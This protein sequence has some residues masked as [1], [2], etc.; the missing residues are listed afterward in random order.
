VQEE[1]PYLHV[2]CVS[3]RLWLDIKVKLYNRTTLPCVHIIIII[4]TIIIIIIIY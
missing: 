1:T 2:I 3:F 4:T